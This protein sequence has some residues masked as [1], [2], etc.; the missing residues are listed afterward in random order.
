MF[1]K[2]F[3]RIQGTVEYEIQMHAV[4]LVVIDATPSLPWEDALD[5]ETFAMAVQVEPLCVTVIDFPK[6]VSVVE[7]AEK[8]FGPVEIVMDA[9]PVPL[10]L[11][12]TLSQGAPGTAI[13]LQ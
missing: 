10:G 9:G 13:Q 8:L 3:N 1:A 5:T 6:I 4:E 12:E 7:R 11:L 2:L